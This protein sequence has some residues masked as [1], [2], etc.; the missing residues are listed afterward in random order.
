MMSDGDEIRVE[1]PRGP[2]SPSSHAPLAKYRL[3]R[4]ALI[5]AGIGLVAPL[6]ATIAVGRWE[7]RLARA[8]FES[9]AEAQ[10]T[11][12]Q[13]GVNEYVSRLTALRTRFESANEDI[14]RNEYQTFSTRLFES[15]PGLVRVSWLPR[16]TR[17][18]RGEYEAAAITDGVPAFR[19][20]AF[21]TASSRRKAM[22]I[23]RSISPP[24][25]RPR[26]S[27]GSTIGAFPNGVR[28]W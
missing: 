25:R 13:N 15:H 16:I 9:M 11:L 19:I 10:A 21:L 6:V 17:K 2:S 18:E 23:S 27:M 12:I 26:S 4:P 22:N 28:R 14:T 3:Y 20:K 7:T 24:S 8:D 1:A 5:A